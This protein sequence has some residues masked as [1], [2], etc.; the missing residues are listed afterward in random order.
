VREFLARAVDWI[1]SP[2]GAKQMPKPTVEARET[3]A[4]LEAKDSRTAQLDGNE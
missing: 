3:L 1:A 2:Q 4:V